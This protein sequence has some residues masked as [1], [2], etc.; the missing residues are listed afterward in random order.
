MKTFAEILNESKATY[1]FNIGIAGELPE[2]IEDRLESVMQKFT[3]RNLSLI[4]I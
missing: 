3:V 4:H 1:S 2:G